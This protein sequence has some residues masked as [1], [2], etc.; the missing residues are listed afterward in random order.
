MGESSVGAPG[1]SPASGAWGPAVASSAVREVLARNRTVRDVRHVAEVGSTQDE[2][3]ALAAA[4]ART[5]TVVVADV[6]RAGRGRS[7]NR[8]DD[9][10]GGGN[11][12]LSLLLDVGA[13]PLDGATVP[14]VPQALGLAVV[15]ACAHVGPEAPALR[16]KWPNDVVLREDPAR[17]AR[18]LAGILVERDRI[19]AAQGAPGG[20]R[21]VLRCGIGMNVALPG[22]VPADRIDLASVIGAR[23]DRA[24]L[25]A[26]LLDALDAAIAALATP[27]V[28]LERLGE[29]SDTVGRRVQ[30]Q[31]PGEDVLIGV[32]SGID[33]TGRLLVTTDGRIRAI[34]SGT[35][36]DHDD[37]GGGT[38]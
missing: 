19:V 12:A 16:L 9:D 15:D 34:L 3:L 14:L 8:W 23:P 2:V 18:K 7:G 1:A 13:P 24:A 22:P 17:P 33:D 36:R 30:V 25:L 27:A 35:V 4:G 38:R 32:A 11:L 20:P 28:L 37:E 5:G 10:P 26:A 21:E 29:V 6:Q 31:V